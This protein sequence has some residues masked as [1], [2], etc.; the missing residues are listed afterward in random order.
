MR[1]FILRMIKP[2]THESNVS[3]A[4]RARYRYCIH[5]KHACLTDRL[6][7]QSGI[8]TNTCLLNL[9]K[10]LTFSQ[11]QIETLLI[12]LR[13]LSNQWIFRLELSRFHSYCH[14]WYYRGKEPKSLLA[15][16]PTTFPVIRGLATF[17]FANQWCKWRVSFENEIILAP[18]TVEIAASSN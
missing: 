6:S 2:E 7:L 3:V 16:H 13:W 4:F 18:R 5:A 10:R 15:L 11:E 1:N 9:K 14:A 17:E 12:T 8:L